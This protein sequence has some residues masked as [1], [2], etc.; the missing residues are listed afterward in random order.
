MAKAMRAQTTNM[1]I[2]LAFIMFILFF[3]GL[4]ATM[5]YWSCSPPPASA[6]G[7]ME[8]SVGGVTCG[9]SQHWMVSGII[10]LVNVTLVV[11]MFVAR[12]FSTLGS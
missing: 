6:Q 10:I 7:I 11:G 3:D 12:V 4:T 2:L 8:T 9:S 1:L 5:G